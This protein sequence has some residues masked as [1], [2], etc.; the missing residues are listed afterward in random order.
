MQH[1]WC[2]RLGRAVRRACGSLRFV[3][4]TC[5]D[6]GV[7]VVEIIAVGIAAIALSLG[8]MWFMTIAAWLAFILADFL[9]ALIA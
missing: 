5:V 6:Y 4:E 8:I 9:G 7:A 1:S 2:Y 3:R